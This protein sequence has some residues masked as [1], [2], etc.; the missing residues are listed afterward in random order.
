MTFGEK[1]G[2]LRKNAGLTQ[3][4]VAQH[5]GISPQAVSKWENDLSCPDIMLLPEIAKLYG[6]TVDALLSDGDFAEAETV[7]E[8]EATEEKE[9]IPAEEKQPEPVETETESKKNLDNANL[10]LKVK[11]LSQQG[12]KVNIKLPV[13]LLKSLKGVL[14]SVLLNS[15]MTGGIDLSSIDLDMIFEL[16]D[17]GVIGDIVDVSTQNGDI[18]KICVERDSV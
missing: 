6:K 4:D 10:F 15:D 16:V 3:D 5:L 8:K 12:D 11:V 14:G 13:S 7:E 17:R 9:E 18:V 2:Y 1:L